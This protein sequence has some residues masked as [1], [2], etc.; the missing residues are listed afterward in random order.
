[1]RFTPEAILARIGQVVIRWNDLES[2]MRAL[3]LSLCGQDNDLSEILTANMGSTALLESLET[4]SNEVA[5]QEMRGHV[6]H[7]RKM[8]EVLRA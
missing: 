6:D 4:I 3:L 2:S 5:P 1:M 7:A 8:F